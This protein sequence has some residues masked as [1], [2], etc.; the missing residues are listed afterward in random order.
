MNDYEVLRT[1][2]SASLM[3]LRDNQQGTLHEGQIETELD[4]VI[5][6][7]NFAVDRSA[8]LSDLER[9]FAILIENATFQQKKNAGGH[10]PARKPYFY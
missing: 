9:S 4:R 6:F 1:M 3:R 5:E 7:G 2:V 8:M 10:A